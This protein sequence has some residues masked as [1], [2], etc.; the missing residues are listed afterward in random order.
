[1]KHTLIK[2]ALGVAAASAMVLGAGLAHAK[3]SIT[4]AV[5]SF[6]AG[7]A[8]GP[9]GIPAMNG[10]KM[11]VDAI[12]K[13]TLPAPYNTKGF[14]GA[15][16]TIIELDEG[17]GATKQVAE[18]RNLVEKRN[19]DAVVGYISSGNCQALAPIVEEL[20]QF[21]IFATCGTPR[22]FEEAP[23]KYLFRT[24]GH[25]TSDNVAAAMY[26]KEKYPN[27]KGYTGI[28]QNYAWGQDSWR[29]FD[30]TLKQI[31]PGSKASDK[32]QF[33]KIFAG[34][35]GSEI[36][37]MS[38][39]SAELVHTSFWGGDL[40]AFIFQGNARGLFKKKIGVFTVGGTAAYRLGKK[41][42]NGLVLGA[43]GPYG[44][45]V[46]DRDTALNKW[47][48]ETYKNIYGIYPSGPAYQYGQG[49][50]AAKIAYD[51]A[52]SDATDEQ[53]AAALRGITFES[54]STTVEMSLGGGHQAVTENGY[55]I[56]KYDDANGEN[57]VTDVKF[58][59]A[60]CVM[61]PE[62]VESVQWINGGMKGAKC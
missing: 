19:V 52:G 60:S 57:V 26:V 32:T 49:I 56:T 48:I 29:D 23:R 11:V 37:A 47:F 50:L 34:Q 18:Y 62:G 38:L 41:L 21:T 45:L 4:I 1:M 46:K 51:K 17:G 15:S 59:P 20:K 28:N 58:Y 10:A 53:L 61:P 2:K 14:G 25:A 27:L 13:G 35:Y 44:I 33:P 39:D 40:E 54:F 3:D 12:N 42:P 6:L 16:A 30:L 55:G 31:L 7:G 24:M 36:S 8:A 5:P 9:F 43:R 22:I